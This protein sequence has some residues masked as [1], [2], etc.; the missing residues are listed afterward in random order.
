MSRNHETERVCDRT[1][2]RRPEATRQTLEHE[3]DAGTDDEEV[4]DLAA[5]ARREPLE[6]LDIAFVEGRDAAERD[7]PEHEG[8]RVSS[9]A[10]SSNFGVNRSQAGGIQEI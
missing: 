6:P 7:E 2:L 10:T 3:I 5:R 9:T 8:D 4:L 1:H